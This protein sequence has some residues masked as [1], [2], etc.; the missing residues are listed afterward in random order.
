MQR[1]LRYY[2]DPIL[3]QKAKPVTD[4]N[5]AYLKQLI[6]EMDEIM[7]K[8]D[9]MGLAAPQV[10][11]LLRVFI[12]RPVI[13]VSPRQWELGPLEIYINPTLSNPS[14]ELWVIEEGCLSI[15]KLQVPVERPLAI[16]IEAYDLEGK[17]FQK[18]A[19]GILARAYMH[20]NDHLNGVLT[21]DRTTKRARQQIDNALRKIKAKYS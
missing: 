1:K 14:E 7:Q 8:N 11:D 19:D 12:F 13:E 20:E 16:T 18:S 9:G 21:I 10:G 2:G 4:F 6:A 3:R 15:P 5:E 17:P